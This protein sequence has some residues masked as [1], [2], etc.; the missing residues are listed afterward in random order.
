L[1]RILII[2]DDGDLRQIYAGLLY[3]N[4]FD[5]DQAASALGGMEAI[6]RAKPDAIVM[7]VY[8]PGV[9]GLEMS[10]L[11]KSAPPTRDIPILCVS[12][13][14]VSP[15]AAE[16]SGCVGFLRKP[17]KPEVLVRSLMRITETPTRGALEAGATFEDQAVI[18]GHEPED[19]T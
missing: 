9:S 13:Y 6:A 14:D 8:L 16:A 11:L 5:V 19:T 1:P 4:G 7:D 17:I 2:D 10:E 12:A 18:P 15:G 3:Y